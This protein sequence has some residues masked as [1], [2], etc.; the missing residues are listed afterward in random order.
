MTERKHAVSVRPQNNVVLVEYLRDNVRVISCSLMHKLCSLYKATE[1]NIL[2]WI[3]LLYYG[4][5]YN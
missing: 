3:L 1:I 4:I 5:E 2:E